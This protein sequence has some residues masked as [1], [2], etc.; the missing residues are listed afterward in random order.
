MLAL[1]TWTVFRSLAKR[2]NCKRLPVTAEAAAPA[3]LLTLAPLF[4]SLAKIV[5]A[6]V[7]CGGGGDA[8]DLLL[9]EL[10]SPPTAAL[11]VS[12]VSVLLLLLL[13]LTAAK[14][15]L[16]SIVLLGLRSLFC[17]AEA[18][19]DELSKFCLIGV[20]LCDLTLL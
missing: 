5:G 8:D 20:A 19:A 2:L 15:T 12:L 1:I 13:L 16:D 14:A 3:L 18:D 17:D 7:A 6:V 9:S 4:E 10:L 11:V